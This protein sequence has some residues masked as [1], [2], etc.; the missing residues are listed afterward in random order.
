MDFLA[1][2]FAQSAP[3]RS[4]MQFA[5]KTIPKGRR[6]RRDRRA[7]KPPRRLAG[8]GAPSVVQVSS[9]RVA[10]MVKL[11]ENTFRA[12]EYRAGER[13]RADVPQDGHRRV[14]AIDAAKTRPLVASCRSDPGPG[15]GGH[16]IP[17]DPSYSSWK[18]AA[19]G[20]ECRFIERAGR[21]QRRDARLLSCRASMRAE[22]G[23]EAR[24][25]DPGFTRSVWPHK[26]DVGDV[27]RVARPGHPGVD[28][29]SAKC[30]VPI[31]PYGVGSS[32][33]AGHSLENAPSMRR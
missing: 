22:L 6:R 33:H 25:T 5:T 16:C 2:A 19:H 20:F 8:H 27:R 9:T 31:D 11:L 12:V 3:I 7:P 4:N 21:G 13:N 10:E 26:K 24:S 17:I 18:C 1:G 28:W 23:E 29:S 14:E 30:K 32:P 15:L